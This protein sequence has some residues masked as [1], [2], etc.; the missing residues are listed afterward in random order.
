MLRRL[1][2]VFGNIALFVPIGLLLPLIFKWTR[3][4]FRIILIT[5]LLSFSMELFQYLWGTGS[6]D[7]DD[8]LLNILG[9]LTG[10]IAYIL[11]KVVLKNE[12]KI[13]SVALIGFLVMVSGGSWIAIREFHLDL[14]IKTGVETKVITL[15]YA[16][17]VVVPVRYADVEGK[18]EEMNG[19]T[20]MI[21][22]FQIIREEKQNS[23]KGTMISIMNVTNNST[24]PLSKYVAS[25]NT[26]VLRKDVDQFSA[27]QFE[28]QYSISSI[29]SIPFKCNNV[30]IWV[31]QHDSMH[32][33][34][35]RYTI[36][37]KQ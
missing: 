6:A 17:T 8:M 35:L 15:P 25:E 12:V 2:N 22:A 10:Y 29:D 18:L 21:N 19:D 20:L 27:R 1:G 28:I 9:G 24:N 26:F 7:I 5:F 30:E 34:T 33:D 37:H 32:V 3:R 11:L 23:D 31:S 4:F 14:G 16:P 13:I 36:F